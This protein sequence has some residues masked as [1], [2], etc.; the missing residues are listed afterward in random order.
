MNGQQGPATDW[1]MGLRA[2]RDQHPLGGVENG[3]P[4]DAALA[5][6]NDDPL[7]GQVAVIRR[8]WLAE[9]DAED[10]HLAVVGDV[11][12]FNQGRCGHRI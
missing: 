1:A 7:V 6:T 3:E 9:G 5:S 11:R 12:L 2:V 8:L 10:I 4:H